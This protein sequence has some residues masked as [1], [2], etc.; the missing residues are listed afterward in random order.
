MLKNPFYDITEA[1]KLFPLLYGAATDGQKER[2]ENAF[3]KYKTV[4]SEDKAYIASSSGRVE[5]IGNHTDHNGGKVISGA[6]NLDTLAFFL[7]A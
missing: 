3:A 4:F 1:E 7:P 6:I 2:Y 5:I